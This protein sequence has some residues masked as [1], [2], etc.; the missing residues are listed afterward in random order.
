MEQAD[1]RPWFIVAG[2]VVLAAAIIGGALLLRDGGSEPA[3]AETTSES[4]TLPDGSTA[5]GEQDAYLDA[6]EP[7]LTDDNAGDVLAV[8]DDGESVCTI[9]LHPADSQSQAI[10]SLIQASGYNETEATVIA[11]A[12]ADHLCPGK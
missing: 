7:H 8:L 6:V 3:A 10:Q 11:R 12:A 2:A 5:T 9:W 4:R 1:R